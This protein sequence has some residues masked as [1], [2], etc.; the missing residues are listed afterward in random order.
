M[1]AETER[2]TVDLIRKGE[3]EKRAQLLRGAGL[4][5]PDG[6]YDVLLVDPPWRYEDCKTE[7]RAIENHYPTMTLEEIRSVKLPAAADCVLFLWA[8]SPKLAEAISVIE[9]W[10]FTYRSCAVWVKDRIGMGYYFRQQHELLLVATKGESG[11]P[12]EGDRCSSVIQAPRGR[13]SEKPEE[14]YAIIERLY[15]RARKCEGWARQRRPG[16]DAWGNEL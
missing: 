13:H 3:R 4:P 5:V 9:S 6:T 10:G 12:E 8:P 11:T 2:V 1:S 16:W 7:N 15:P 14:V